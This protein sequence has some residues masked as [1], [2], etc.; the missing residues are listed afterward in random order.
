[1]MNMM[2]WSEL[3]FLCFILPPLVS[4]TSGKKFVFCFIYSTE[5]QGGMHIQLELAYPVLLY[6]DK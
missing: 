5:I 2:K 4:F 1:M 3:F 6:Y